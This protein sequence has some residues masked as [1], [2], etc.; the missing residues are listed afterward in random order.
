MANLLFLII[1]MKFA[2]VN[3]IETTSRRWPI[4]TNLF[5]RA[6]KYTLKNLYEDVPF[7]KGI[8]K[9]LSDKKFIT[10]R[11]DLK[12]YKTL[13]K[14]QRFK[15]L[16]KIND[17]KFM[18]DGERDKTEDQVYDKMVNKLFLVLNLLDRLEQDPIVAQ[19]NKLQK[20]VNH[21]EMLKEKVGFEEDGQ[22][23]NFDAIIPD[24]Y[25]G[26]AK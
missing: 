11:S 10:A 17:L 8:I 15:L 26:G 14:I 24:N 18:T 3:P 9:N 21:I 19:I 1:V 13:V 2:F 4:P 16:I 7:A 12:E 23:V 20:I 6:V 25:M 22:I 5:A